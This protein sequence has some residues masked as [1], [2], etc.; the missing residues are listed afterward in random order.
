MSAI[1][2]VVALGNAAVSS[3]Q[4]ELQTISDRLANLPV[5]GATDEEVSAVTD[6]VNQVSAAEE[7]ARSL[8]IQQAVGGD[9]NPPGNLRPTG[10]PRP[11]LGQTFKAQAQRPTPL[12]ARPALPVARPGAVRPGNQQPVRR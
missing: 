6:L 1:L 5:G 8:A 2:D 4:S 9:P 7:V 3:L 12:P 11:I 10:Q